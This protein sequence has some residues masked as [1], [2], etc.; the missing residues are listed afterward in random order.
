[1]VDVVGINSAVP[2]ATVAQVNKLKGEMTAGSF[3]VF[4]GPVKAQDGSIKVPAG[5]NMSDEELNSINWFIEGVN[6]TVP[7]K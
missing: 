5:R 4:A 2:A 1:M 6:G 7:G 3:N